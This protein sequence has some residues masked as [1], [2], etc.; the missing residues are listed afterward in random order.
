MNNVMKPYIWYWITFFRPPWKICLSSTENKTPIDCPY[1][2]L[3][4]DWQMSYKL[5]ACWPSHILSAYDRS[6]LSIH[7]INKYLC[8]CNIAVGMKSN[9]IALWKYKIINILERDFRIPVTWSKRL[10]G[11]HRSSPLKYFFKEGKWFLVMVW[12]TNFII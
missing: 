4:E 6:L 8:T 7:T 11:V 9:Y 2:M 3:F 1:V 5:W 10:R 12:V